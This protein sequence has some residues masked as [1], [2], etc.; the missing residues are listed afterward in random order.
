MQPLGARS[1]PLDV[2][3][4]VAT[5]VLIPGADGRAWY[6][7]RVAPLLRERGHHVVA[8]DLPATDPA[9]GLQEYTAAILDAIGGRDDDLIVVAQS[10]AGF[11]APLAVERAPVTQL[12][13]LNAMVPRPGESAGEWWGNTRQ[14]AAR[15]E[16]YAA[17][18][19]DLP[20]EFD[21]LEAFF[22]DVP[23]D[24][25]EQAV[26]MGEPAVRFDT[27]FSQPWPLPAWPDVPTRFLQGRDDR[28]FPLE[29]QRRV[30][31]E[32]L[33]IPVDEM[34]GGHLVALSHPEELA[35]RLERLRVP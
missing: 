30:V 20:A 11:T 15:A 10:L 18:G 34:P 32:R 5:Y 7:H 19:R 17:E 35:E 9:A 4:A 3:N 6:W 8:V 1:T 31:A 13:L 28:F 26:A 16:H 21:P 27:L 12:I 25:V 23:A 22:H 29:F 2:V 33:H 14:A 24:V